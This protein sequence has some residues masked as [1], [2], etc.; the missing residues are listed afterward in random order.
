MAFRFSTWGYNTPLR[1]R[2]GGICCTVTSLSFYLNQRVVRFFEIGYACAVARVVFAEI[3]LVTGF[4]LPC[5]CTGSI[6]RQPEYDPFIIAG[7]I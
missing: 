5:E 3:I 2:S 1:L 4:Q 6:S 7:T